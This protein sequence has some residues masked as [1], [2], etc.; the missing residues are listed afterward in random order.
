[1]FIVN[2]PIGQVGPPVSTSSNQASFAPDTVSSREAPADI[3]LPRPI[4]ASDA[5][6]KTSKAVPEKDN[7]SEP[8]GGQSSYIDL[9]EGKEAQS[10]FEAIAQPR[11]DVA[12]PDIQGIENRYMEAISSQI[13]PKIAAPDPD[14]PGDTPDAALLDSTNPFERANSVLNRI[15]LRL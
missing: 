2:G 6:S 15:D 9:F 14:P 4:M 11:Q 3:A 1:M 5:A 12:Q 10:V 7:T 13:Q 8:E